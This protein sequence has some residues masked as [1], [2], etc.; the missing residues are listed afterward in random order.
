MA[1]IRRDVLCV[2]LF[3]FQ[4]WILLMCLVSSLLMTDSGNSEF[5]MMSSNETLILGRNSNM[6]VIGIM[7]ALTDYLTTNVRQSIDKRNDEKDHKEK[8][9]HFERIQSDFENHK[10]RL[11]TI[12][13]EIKLTGLLMGYSQH[14]EK[15]KHSLLA[16]HQFL[17]S[18]SEINENIFMLEAAHLTNSIS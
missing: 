11:K 8:I 15:I 12:N 3:L 7:M 16:L 17:E 1:V 18:P 6:E 13:K 14:E 4:M 2:K 5:E 10:E 9:T